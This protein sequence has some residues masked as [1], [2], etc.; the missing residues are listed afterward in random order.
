MAEAK[1]QEEPIVLE[2]AGFWRRFA[3]FL[4]DGIILV[5]V[6][7]MFIPFW[8]RGFFGIQGFDS[9]I[10][11]WSWAAFN[12]SVGGLFQLV[13]SA[14]YFIGFWVVSSAFGDILG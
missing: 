4:I 7:S 5:V 8:G 3:A 13:I 2:F 11:N 10:Y 6:A 14:L 9:I 1:T 12:W